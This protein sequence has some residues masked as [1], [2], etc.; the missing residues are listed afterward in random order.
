MTNGDGVVE[1]VEEFAVILSSVSPD[2]EGR[3][4][5]STVSTASVTIEDNDKVD[6]G[7]A[8]IDY[9]VFEGSGS[10]TL[11][12]AV[13]SG[14]IAEGLS[15]TVVLMTVDGTADNGDYASLMETLRFS[16]DVTTLTVSVSISADT[17]VE[18]AEEF[19]VRLSGESVSESMSVTTVRIRDDDSGELRWRLLTIRYPREKM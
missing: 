1:G 14:D 12:V 16:S 2:I 17:V 7:F 3:I 11:T 18:G 9:R 15:V 4:K 10:V 8:P 5:I 6:I 13:L 19:G